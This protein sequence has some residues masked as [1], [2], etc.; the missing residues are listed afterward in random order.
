MATVSIIILTVLMWSSGDET[1]AEQTDDVDADA[2]H[3]NDGR[4]RRPLDRHHDEPSRL[5]MVH[6]LLHITSKQYNSIITVCCYY[7]STVTSSDCATNIAETVT[8]AEWCFWLKPVR[9]TTSPWGEFLILKWCILVHSQRKRRLHWLWHV[10]RSAKYYSGYQYHICLLNWS[11]QLAPRTQKDTLV[12]KDI[13]I[14]LFHPCTFLWP[15]TRILLT[16]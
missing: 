5:D 1:G 11:R 2:Q 15:S 14:N 16:M 12:T 7:C 10:P 4:F 9:G 3:A 8:I 13:I 6:L